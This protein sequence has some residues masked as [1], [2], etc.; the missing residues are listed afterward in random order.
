MDVS[1]EFQE[2]T[3][4][5]SLDWKKANREESRVEQ[6]RERASSDGIN[7]LW[8]FGCFSFASIMLLRSV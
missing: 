4:S 6:E 8:L 2:A 1:L 7:M 5:R 3:M